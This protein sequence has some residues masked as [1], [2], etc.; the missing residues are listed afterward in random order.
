M[1]DLVH[2]H[3]ETRGAWRAWLTAH[4]TQSASVWF[5]YGKVGSG[6]PR[7]DPDEAIEEALCFG[8]IDSLPRTL[9]DA[10]SR[11]LFSPRKPGSNWSALNKRRAEAMIAR[12]LMAPAGQAKIDAAKAD[13]SWTALDAVE[14]LTVPDDLAAAFTRHPGS[15]EAFASFPKSARRGILEW[16]LNAKRAPTREKRLEETAR[17]AA[18]GERANQWTRR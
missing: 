6:A 16:I 13:G 3:P 9:D 4:H 8:W 12:G 14:A 15:A 1:D 18:R 11:L 17:L 2:I 7:V 5:V 10:R